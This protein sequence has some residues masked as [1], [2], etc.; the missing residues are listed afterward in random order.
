MKV[1]LVK[2]RD[3]LGIVASVLEAANLG[4]NK[5]HI[6]FAAKLSFKLLEKYLDLAVNAGLV[7]V[8]GCTYSVTD[9]GQEYLRRYRGF[10]A[11]Y[12]NVQEL[13][14]ALS[15]EREHLSRLCERHALGSISSDIDL[16]V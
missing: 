10:Q 1:C 15:S 9:R 13:L 4:S 12:T 3:R 8:N 7:K 11:R 5:T 16:G 6:M 2:N 14:E